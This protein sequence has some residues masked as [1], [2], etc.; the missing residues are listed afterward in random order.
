MINLTRIQSNEL[1]AQVLQSEDDEAMRR[2]CLEDLFF[3]IR[4]ACRR[5]DINRDWLFDRCREVEA[6][7]DGYLDLWAREHY[8]SSI[9]TFGLTLQ[10]ILKDPEVTIGIFS[11]TRP[12]AKGFLV[13]IKRELEINTFLKGLFPDILYDNPQKEAPKW[14]LDDGIIVK[15]KSNPKESTIEA[16]GLVDGQPTSKH[17]QIMIYDDTVTRE[18]V[19][20]PDMIAKVQEAFGLSQNLES[21]NPDKPSRKRYIGTRYHAQDMYKTMIDRGTARP[22]VYAATKDGTFEGEPV[23]MTKEQ[24]VNKLRDQGSYV[25]STQMLQNPIADK[26]MG[27]K[28]DWL[29]TYHVLKN[30]EGWNFYLLVDPAGEKKKGSDYTVMVVIGLAPDKN[31]YLVDGLRDR[32]N[33][34]QRANALMGFHR[35]WRP[36][37]VGYEKYGKDS[38]IEHIKYIQEQEGYRFEIVALGGAMSKNDRIRRMVPIFEQHRFYMPARLL[39]NTVD[40]KVADLVNIFLNEEYSDFPVSTHDDIFDCIARITDEDLKAVFPLIVQQQPLAI[41]MVSEKD[42]DPLE[43]AVISPQVMAPAMSD[44]KSMMTRSG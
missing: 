39:Y 41:P 43:R 10:D 13:Q 25:F 31:Y 27:F 23:F 6:N 37:G 5:E 7:P 36:R 21:S 30:Y 32:M 24:L 26:A 8:K 44:W 22:R 9:I 42:Y 33:L 40:G 17:Y 15:R 12:I 1:Y 28:L 20:T 16:W 3:L 38:D 2:L 14:S 35:K 19:T 29:M 11:H 18:S 4:I 34:T